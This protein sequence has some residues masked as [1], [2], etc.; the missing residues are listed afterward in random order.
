MWDFPFMKNDYSM[1]LLICWPVT[2]IYA[3]PFSLGK[4]FY[5]LDR[6]W[7]EVAETAC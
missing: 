5:R 3:T 6:V 2:K 7:A 1:Q 4:F